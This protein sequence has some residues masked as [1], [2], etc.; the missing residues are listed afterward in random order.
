MPHPLAQQLAVRLVL[1]VGSGLLLFSGAIGV[2]TFRNVF[3]EQ[4]QAADS[5]LTQ[6]VA[7]VRGQAEVA[8]YARNN[9]IAAEVID[10]LLANSV[11]LAVRMADDADFRAEKGSRRN[12]GAREPRRYRLYSPV[13]HI[14]PIGYLEIIINDDEVNRLAA[15]TAWFY[16]NLMLAQ[17]VV[18]V[19]LLT[20]VLRWKIISPIT[21]LA[22]TLE[23]IHPGSAER[24]ALEVAHADDEIGLLTRRTNAMLDAAQQAVRVIEEKEQSKSMFFA[25]VSH[26]LRQPI[27]AI[28]LFLDALKRTAGDAER[29][30]LIQSLE[31]AANALTVNLNELLDISKL[32]AGAVKPQ[33]DWVNVEE[34]FS[35][36]DSSFSSAAF[37]QHL[38]FKLWYPHRE[39]ALHTD[40][41]L[42]NVILANLTGNALK[43]TTKGGV[44]VG[45]RLRGD[46]CVIQVWDTGCGIADEH[47]AYIYEEFFQAANPNRDSNNGYGLGLAIVR[48]MAN[49]LGYQLSCRSQ[50]DKGSV[51]ELHL[52]AGTVR[53]QSS[54]SDPAAGAGNIPAMRSSSE[55][56]DAVAQR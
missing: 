20:I 7:T 56:T 46:G 2:L 49:L 13:D 16:T 24:I 26:D 28:N 54:R 15:H 50:L 47:L 33:R 14:S 34:V 11:I 21:R 3:Q 55:I 23:K 5:L 30:R 40:R 27:T 31:A 25:A 1:I 18:A 44:L 51:F 38:R 39:L 29:K 19:I 4:I 52:P 37:Q 17:I 12:T 8:V 45:L 10:G 48:R 35:H 41:H 22:Q 32:D 36:L 9:E 6:L 53:E 43:N 42:L